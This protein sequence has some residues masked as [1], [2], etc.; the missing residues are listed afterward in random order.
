ML[1]VVV[2]D[3]F[4]IDDVSGVGSSPVLAFLVLILMTFF[5]PFISDKDRHRKLFLLVSVVQN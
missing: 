3:A 4:I 5:H 2:W 1:N